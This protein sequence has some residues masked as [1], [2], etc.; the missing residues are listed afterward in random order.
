MTAAESTPN[1]APD[2][3]A[4]TARKPVTIATVWLDGCS[5]CHMSFLDMDERLIEIAPLIQIVH[6]PIVDT[7]EIPSGTDVG[8]IEGA[9][10]NE[11]DLA[12][13]KK[14]RKACGF[15]ISLGDCAVTGNV[16]SMR[17]VFELSTVYDRA[18]HENTDV[19][20]VTPDNVVPPLLP[21]VLPVHAAVDVDLYVPGCPPPADAIYYVLTELIAGRTP[22]PMAVTRF[23]K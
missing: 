11:D 1:T 7:K 18:Y 3:P 15:L 16:P 13:A 12:K 22:D 8:I 23:G 4:E 10:S 19:N 5:G 17:N 20:P 14:M 9:I 2:T 21:K 6:S